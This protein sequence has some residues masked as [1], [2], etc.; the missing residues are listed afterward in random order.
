MKYKG[1]YIS[2]TPDCDPNEGGY[3][4]QVYDD[5]DMANQIDDCSHQFL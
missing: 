2:I 1:L 3:Y 5:E 4:C